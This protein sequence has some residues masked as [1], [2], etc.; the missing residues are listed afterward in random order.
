MK[1]YRIGTSFFALFK[2]LCGH[3][4]AV[5]AFALLNVS[6]FQSSDDFVTCVWFMWFVALGGDTRGFLSDV[7][8]AIMLYSVP[9][10]GC[11]LNNVGKVFVMVPLL[12]DTP[13]L[14]V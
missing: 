9:R 6:N 2:I 14:D 10:K 7:K 3:G 13:F 1:E 8:D 12:G 5:V 11:N 4:H